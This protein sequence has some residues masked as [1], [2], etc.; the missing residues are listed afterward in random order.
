MSI[1]RMTPDSSDSLSD[2][3][4]SYI[5]SN[6]LE[7]NEMATRRQSA[8]STSLNRRNSNAS[9]F[10]SDR[11]AV[12]IEQ[13]RWSSLRQYLSTVDGSTE[14][15]LLL[16]ESLPRRK[17]N[18][19]NINADAP[20]S[21]ISTLLHI[22]CKKHPP[23]DII[24]RMVQLCPTGMAAHQRDTSGRYPLHIAAAW[25]AS[26]QVVKFLLL[27]NI[28][29]ASHLAKDGKSPLHLCCEYGCREG[30]CD[31]GTEKDCYNFVKGPVLQVVYNLFIASPKTINVEDIHGCAP[32]EYAITYGADVKVVKFLQKLS[33]YMWKR[34]TR[35]AQGEVL[36]ASD[37]IHYA[38]Y[39]LR[40]V[41]KTRSPAS[42]PVDDEG[43]QK[44]KAS[45]VFT[46][47]NEILSATQRKS[48][49][50]ILG[51]VES[52]PAVERK[53]HFSLRSFSG[54]LLDAVRCFSR[55]SRLSE[56]T[57]ESELVPKEFRGRTA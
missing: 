20:S 35:M 34:E 55:S 1:V 5:N 57:T 3:K 31:P 36:D 45:V 44:I 38:N 56:L 28:N 17:S 32:L 16:T 13:R 40:M 25:G 46:I 51:S 2:S 47:C 27:Q 14:L 48:S 30:A 29:A 21:P 49:V 6:K 24:T 37:H 11:V 7:I 10:V 4:V 42:K 53:G 9:V 12:L 26:P 52:F 23:E 19:S 39:V 43:G 50:S 15:A 8:L 22:T 33:V 54:N 18:G 41:T